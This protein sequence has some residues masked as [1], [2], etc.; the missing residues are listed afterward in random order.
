M[1]RMFSRRNT[2]PAPKPVEAVQFDGRNFRECGDFL[3]TY[4]LH[5]VMGTSDWIVKESNSFEVW[6]PGG[7]RANF[8][9]YDEHP[10]TPPAPT[11]PKLK[12]SIGRMVLYHM[13]SATGMAAIPAVIKLVSH[14]QTL[15][16]LLCIDYEYQRDDSTPFPVRLIQ[17]GEARPDTDYCE[18]LPHEVEQAKAGA[19]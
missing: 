17:P 11:H 16:T 8:E 19:T 15:V 10:P 2:G 4:G 14:D 18:F 7:F 1:A 13:H 3:G 6:T 12:P 5:A 9:V